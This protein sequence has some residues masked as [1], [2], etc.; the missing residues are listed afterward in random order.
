MGPKA[1]EPPDA[2]HGECAHQHDCLDPVD[3]QREPHGGGRPIDRGLVIAQHHRAHDHAE[4]VSEWKPDLIGV[5]VLAQPG[6]DLTHA[7]QP[8]QPILV[9]GGVADLDQSLGHLVDDHG[10]AHAIGMILGDGERGCELGIAAWGQ[11]NIE[12]RF[13]RLPQISRHDHGAG[14]VELLIGL[15]VVVVVEEA[16]EADGERDDQRYRQPEPQP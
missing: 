14:D 13:D 10:K 2:Q 1:R 16:D 4:T 8:S 15:A 6:H 5:V 9:G 3:E 12:A 11:S 7:L